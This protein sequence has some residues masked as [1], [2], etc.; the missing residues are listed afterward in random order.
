MK[1]IHGS[2]TNTNNPLVKWGVDVSKMRRRA[3]EAYKENYNTAVFLWPEF[4]EEYDYLISL[5]E[6]NKSEK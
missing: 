5:R 6:K 1:I 2:D 4:K 3:F